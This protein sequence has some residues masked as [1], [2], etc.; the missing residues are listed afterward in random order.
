V[1]ALL[2]RID[3][4]RPAVPPDAP[5]ELAPLVLEF[6]ES[7]TCNRLGAAPQVRREQPFAFPLGETGVLVT[8][9]FDVLA[10]ER[11]GR[12]LVV[13]YKTGAVGEYATQ[14]LIYAIAALRTGAV[15]IDVVHVFLEAGPAV[16][17][18][19]RAGD[20]PALEAALRELA[21]D[22]IEGRFAVTDEPHRA[23]CAGC[24]ALGGLCSWPVEAAMRLAVDRLF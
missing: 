23:L 6:T 3:F 18:T 12:L 19:Y 22:V 7:E 2:A 4:R 17:R 5:P 14:R 10:T 20:L 21:G 13:D 16:A 1:H 15:E 11:P 24:P 9:T 8:G